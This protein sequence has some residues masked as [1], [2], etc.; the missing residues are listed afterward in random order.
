MFE[1]ILLLLFV[2]EFIHTLQS[3]LQRVTMRHALT[4]YVAQICLTNKENTSVEICFDG[5][6]GFLNILTDRIRC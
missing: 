4:D 3:K 5:N 2:V 1:I 6:N